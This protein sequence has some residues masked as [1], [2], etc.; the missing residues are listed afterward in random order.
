MNKLW[1]VEFFG[2]KMD[3]F[4]EVGQW[5][6]ANKLDNKKELENG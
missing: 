4:G 6:N 1:L 5:M 3:E 2:V